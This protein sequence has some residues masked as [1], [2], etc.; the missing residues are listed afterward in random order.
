[1]EMEDFDAI[2]EFLK[3]PALDV[4]I[5][6]DLFMEPDPE[7]L[8]RPELDVEIDLFE[9]HSNIKPTEKRK[10]Q[11][12]RGYYMSIDYLGD[13]SLK[14][15]EIP[16]SPPDN[17]MRDHLNIY[18]LTDWNI[19]DALHLQIMLD[20]YYDISSYIVVTLP[21][22]RN[23]KYVPT[24]VVHVYCPR[25][26]ITRR[27]NLIE[28]F[29]YRFV[30]VFCDE[31]VG[32]PLCSQLVDHRRRTLRDL[33]RIKYGK[34]FRYKHMSAGSP[35]KMIYCRI[36]MTEIR[37]VYPGELLMHGHKLCMQKN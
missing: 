20:F 13:M 3:N 10:N 17:I 36:H 25:H 29:I 35:V 16:M 30:C 5:S 24:S 33:I 4:D 32:K 14:L 11:Y 12:K 15:P 18:Y 22:E 23:H 2:P 8:N 9:E 26:N 27:C 19:K 7:F 31:Y 1:M 28:L 34:V 6:A 37:N 21:M